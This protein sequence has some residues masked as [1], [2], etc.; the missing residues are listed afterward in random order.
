MKITRFQALNKGNTIGFFSFEMN[1][2]YFN[3][4]AVLRSKTGG[5]FVSPPSRKYEKDGQTKYS[6]Y[7]GFVDKAKYEE[8]QKKIISELEPHLKQTV[9][10]TPKNSMDEFSEEIPF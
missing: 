1:G 3:D 7:W 10:E 6:N 9:V 5:Y 4:C 2:L 8:F